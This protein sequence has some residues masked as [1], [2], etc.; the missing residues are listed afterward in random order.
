[1]GGPDPK[2]EWACNLGVAVKSFETRKHSTTKN[3]NKTNSVTRINHRNRV[4][5]R[6]LTSFRFSRC[7]KTRL[8]Q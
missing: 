4:S 8:E 7:L 5:C 3:K 6:R 1:M 2:R